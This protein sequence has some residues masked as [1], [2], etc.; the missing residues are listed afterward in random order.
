MVIDIILNY[1]VV[2]SWADKK[3]YISAMAIMQDGCRFGTCARVNIW[4]PDA[5]GS[6]LPKTAQEIIDYPNQKVASLKYSKTWK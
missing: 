5:S 1:I 4:Q 2:E 6:M 3:I